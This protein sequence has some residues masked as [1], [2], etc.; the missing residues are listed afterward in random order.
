M[1]AW[2]VAAEASSSSAATP[3]ASCPSTHPSRSCAGTYSGATGASSATACVPCGAGKRCM[4]Y[5]ARLAELVSLRIA[6]EAAR[7]EYM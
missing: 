3:S 2:R 5:D 4:W 7:R 6:G 1:G